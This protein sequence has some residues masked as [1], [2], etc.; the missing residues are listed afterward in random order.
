MSVSGCWGA[1][2][3]TTS[4]QRRITSNERVGG[5]KR[6]QLIVSCV[7]PLQM[8]PLFMQGNRFVNLQVKRFS[9]AFFTNE[10]SKSE[11]VAC[12]EAR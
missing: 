3:T 6:C 5:L 7:F 9:E 2:P 10:F 4:F 11:I 12:Y 8:L 1:E